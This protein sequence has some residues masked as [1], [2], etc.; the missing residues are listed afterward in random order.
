MVQIG[1]AAMYN[2]GEGVLQDYVEAYAWA[3][4][5]SL[6]GEPKMKDALAEE[7]TI[8]QIAAGQARAKEIAKEMEQASD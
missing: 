8:D 3:L 2:S 7:L 1:I 6:N 5:A 4:H